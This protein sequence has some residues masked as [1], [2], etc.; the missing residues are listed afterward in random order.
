MVVAC[1]AEWGAKSQF[2]FRFR[3]ARREET[4]ALMSD[5]LRARASVNGVPATA[6]C[7]NV[8]CTKVRRTFVKYI[9]FYHETNC[10][11]EALSYTLHRHIILKSHLVTSFALH[12]GAR[13]ATQTVGRLLQAM[14][15]CRQGSFCLSA[16]F[17]SSQKAFSPQCRAIKLITTGNTSSWSR[18]WHSEVENTVFSEYCYFMARRAN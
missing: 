18:W 17:V 13:E 1:I 11:I 14:A 16:P 4:R 9:S 6:T 3:M 2:Q 10:D 5:A 7:G 8:H 15:V 12:N